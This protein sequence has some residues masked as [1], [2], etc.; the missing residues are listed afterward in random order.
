LTAA[1]QVRRGGLLWR[2]DPAAPVWE[3]LL[4]L[5]DVLQSW[6]G[7]A[8]LLD[9]RDGSLFGCH[10]DFCCTDESQPFPAATYQIW[11]V[12]GRVDQPYRELKRKVSKMTIS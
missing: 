12:H 4:D 6:K 8:R 11:Q 10:S 1:D 5:L 3:D 2:G 7:A 9:L